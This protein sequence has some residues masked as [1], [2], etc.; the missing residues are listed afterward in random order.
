MAVHSQPRQ[1]VAVHWACGAVLPCVGQPLQ[2]VVTSWATGMLVQQGM[3]LEALQGGG[4]ES[5]TLSCPAHWM[6]PSAL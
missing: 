3:F 6:V 5:K 4:S 2:H 1:C